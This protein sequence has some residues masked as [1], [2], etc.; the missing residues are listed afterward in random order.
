MNG[1]AAPQM[2]CAPVAAGSTVMDASALLAECIRLDTEKKVTNKILD[3]IEE[4]LKECKERVKNL[5][6]E[7]GVSSMKSGKKN[8]YI[9]KQIWGGIAEDVERDKL[10]EA[11]IAA[12]MDGYITCNA[13]KLSS[14][15]REI[16]QQHSEFM[17]ADGDVTASPEEIAAA[18]PEPFNTM[19][20]VTEKI[21]IGIRK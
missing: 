5:F 19:F 21:D 16:V 4:Q 17:N 8:V 2:D 1:E 3:G 12:D 6:I 18:L 13:T 7:M 11:L 15:V 14:Y 9:K 20:K 10:A